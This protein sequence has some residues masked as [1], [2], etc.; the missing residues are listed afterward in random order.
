M[1]I[2]GQLL[3]KLARLYIRSSQHIVETQVPQD[4][5]EGTGNYTSLWSFQM[6]KIEARAIQNARH[7]LVRA[8]K[9][10]R[11]LENSEIILTYRGCCY[12]K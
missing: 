9:E 11:R 7:T 8:Q 2:T 6:T 4:W 10:L 5:W 1:E 12:A 3:T